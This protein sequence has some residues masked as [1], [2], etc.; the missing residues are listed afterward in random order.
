MSDEDNELG[1]I[2][3][4]GRSGVQRCGDWCRH[5][6][7]L[8]E[9]RWPGYGRCVHPLSLRNGQVFHPGHDCAVGEAAVDTDPD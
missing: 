9:D 1:E 6:V 7:P 2:A 3:Y 5:Y 8:D 4:R